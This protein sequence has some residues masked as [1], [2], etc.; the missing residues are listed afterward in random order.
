MPRP[1]TCSSRGSAIPGASTSA[2]GTTSAGWS[3]TSWP[4]APMPR[5]ARSSTAGWPRLGS[6]EQ[7]LALLKPET[8]M[9]ESGRSIGGRAAVLQGRADG[10]ARRPRR[11]RSRAW[12]SPGAAGRRARRPQRAALD[13]AGARV[14][15]LP[16]PAD[17]RGRPGRGDPRPVADY[18]LSPFEDEVDA[19]A[20]TPAGGRRGRDDRPRRARSRAGALQLRAPSAHNRHAR[21]QIRHVAAGYAGRGWRVALHPLPGWGCWGEAR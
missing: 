4:G 18:V 13:R 20:L 16:A 21:S 19:D 8:Y 12:S 6:I 7:R 14:A 2:R 9:N 10:V 1:S 11:R 17:R 5:S 15:G 3:S